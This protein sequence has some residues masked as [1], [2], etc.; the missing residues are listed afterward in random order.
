MYFNIL[1]NFIFN[2]NLVRF[3]YKYLF[4]NSKDF[5]FFYF[6]VVIFIVINEM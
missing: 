4:W 3:V 5:V 1:L 6:N 2:F